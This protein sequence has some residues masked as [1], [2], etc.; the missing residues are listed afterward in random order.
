MFQHKALLAYRESGCR[1]D[2][3]SELS[4][5]QPSIRT[6]FGHSLIFSLGFESLQSG[7]LR[8]IWTERQAVNAKCSCS[9]QT[10]A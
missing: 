6:R 3:H 9:S 5:S 4:C 10:H 8:R 2:G 7:T 1:K